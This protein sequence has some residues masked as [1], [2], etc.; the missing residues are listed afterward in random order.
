MIFLG[1]NNGRTPNN[2]FPSSLVLLLDSVIT[3]YKGV[4]YLYFCA[5]SESLAIGNHKR[6]YRNF[7]LYVAGKTIFIRSSDSTSG[8]VEKFS[9]CLKSYENRG[10]IY[11]G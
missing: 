1:T 10:G 3:V 9:S 6:E 11:Y 2:F 5:S 8:F 7:E 4:L